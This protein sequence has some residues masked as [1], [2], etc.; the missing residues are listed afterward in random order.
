M[1]K[2]VK[3]FLN[4][5]LNAKEAPRPWEPDVGDIEKISPENFRLI[6]SII[7]ICRSITDEQIENYVKYLNK[8]LENSG[9][10]KK[11]HDM[12]AKTKTVKLPDE[13]FI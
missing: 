10:F 13:D 3:G 4:D 8:T 2:S 5:L 1:D 6:S 7:K 12:M 9:E 11:F